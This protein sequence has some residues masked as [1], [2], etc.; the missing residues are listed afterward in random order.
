MMFAGRR[1][2]NRGE[3]K[4][5][6]HHGAL[7]TRAMPDVHRSGASV[8]PGVRGG[9]LGMNSYQHDRHVVQTFQC[10]VPGEASGNG[11]EMDDKQTVHVL[12]VADGHGHKGDGHVVSAF[13]MSDLCRMLDQFD[14]LPPPPHHLPSTYLV[15][16]QEANMIDEAAETVD[17]DGGNNE[18]GSGGDDGNA[19]GTNDDTSTNE[20]NSNENSHKNGNGNDNNTDDD[21]DGKNTEQNN[22]ATGDSNENIDSGNDNEDDDG[23]EKET[24]NDI[25]NKNGINKMD[26]D[27]TPT[28]SVAHRNLH[29]A[30]LALDAASIQACQ[31]FHRS[32]YAGSTL[33]LAIHNDTTNT[34][35]IAN[36]GDSTCFILSFSTHPPSPPSS[37]S[38]S[39]TTH[40]IRFRTTPHDASSPAE[41][42]RVENAGGIFDRKGRVLG[43]ISMTR[44]LGDNDLKGERNRTH[45]HLPG[46][47]PYDSRMFISDPDVTVTD[48]RDDDFALV[49]VS[50][51]VTDF[52]NEGVLVNLVASAFTGGRSATAAAKMVTDRVLRVNGHDN[53]TAVVHW[54]GGTGRTPTGGNSNR[55]REDDDDSAS[56]SGLQRGGSREG[57][58]MGGNKVQ[59]VQHAQEQ[60]SHSSG[61]LHFKR[62]RHVNDGTGNRAG[63]G[64]V[65]GWTSTTT[66]T[67]NEQEKKDEQVDQGASDM[68]VPAGLAS[69][70]GGHRRKS[71]SAATSPTGGLF[72]WLCRR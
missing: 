39:S 19:E 8:T 17:G 25:K 29:N 52:V 22:D 59:D 63:G 18:E 4:R 21:D 5:P 57:S 30:I 10:K 33:A 70:Q 34:I 15:P 14:C 71:D 45:F 36:V 47:P 1:R 28:D 46:Q 41:R 66:T 3:A 40:D 31:R 38:P 43:H 62:G 23:K 27:K 2:S 50:D 16:P 48:V 32:C 56:G 13:I 44:A 7:T 72:K 49:L 9:S 54:L 53:A 42:R 6:Q 37:A 26:N 60:G 51:G 67:T 12:A 64:V 11:K 68:V 65:I 61:A 35:H 55:R 69:E 24:D 20:T 58:G